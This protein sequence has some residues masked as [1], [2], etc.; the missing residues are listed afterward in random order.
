MSES[1]DSIDLSKSMEVRESLKPKSSRKDKREGKLGKKKTKI[2]R[3]QM[4]EKIA[5]NIINTDE[6]METENVLKYDVEK[7]DGVGL[8]NLKQ[9][10]NT[11]I[12]LYTQYGSGDGEK[13]IGSFNETDVDQRIRNMM[14]ELFYRGLEKYND[15]L[16]KE[17]K[18]GEKVDLSTNNIDK[19]FEFET[20]YENIRDKLN[21]A[22]LK[23]IITY[24]ANSQIYTGWSMNPMYSMYYVFYKALKACKS[25]KTQSYQITKVATKKAKT[26]VVFNSKGKDME[27]FESIK[28]DKLFNAFQTNK[29]KVLIDL[30][31]WNSITTDSNNY[32]IS[33]ILYGINYAPFDN[34]FKY[35]VLTLSDIYAI[36]QPYIDKD[37]SAVKWKKI[38][39]NLVIESL[40]TT[41][42]D[43]QKTKKI[44]ES[45][46]SMKKK[47]Y[48]VTGND[49]NRVALLDSISKI[50]PL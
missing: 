28:T 49:Q 42:T 29:M 14:D 25:S 45:L 21:L 5:K 50:N 16:E 34:C 26:G 37:G 27:Y 8:T 3:E 32:S 40:P 19:I 7:G 9:N 41:A 38:S 18:T 36:T 23:N 12:K 46:K 48:S 6:K 35:G 1:S 30:N 2:S 4:K 15:M 13:L 39:G 44:D 24:F 20:T 31:K 22:E 43:I 10:I 17:G 47:L 33:E 11:E